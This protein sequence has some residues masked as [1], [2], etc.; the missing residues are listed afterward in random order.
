MSTC[1][2]VALSD[3]ESVIRAISKGWAVGQEIL[4]WQLVHLFCESTATIG[5]LIVNS[6]KTTT[7]SVSVGAYETQYQAFD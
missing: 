3:V 7:N 6:S 1:D 4:G 2:L 5:F